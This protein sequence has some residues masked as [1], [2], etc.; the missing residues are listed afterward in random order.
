MHDLRDAGRALRA[1]PLLS[2]AAV[3]SL[4]LGIGASTAIFSIF[5]SLLLKPLPVRTPETLVALA[6]DRAGEDAAL[7]YPIWSAI[8]D[9]GALNDAFVWS[10][11]RLGVANLGEIR[12]LEAVWTSGNFFKVIGLPAIAGRPFGDA[13]DRRGGGPD[14]PVAVLSYRAARRL[15][16]EPSAAIGKT[17]VIERLPFTIVGVTPRGFFGLNIGTDADVVLP[18][19]AEPMLNRVPS[20]LKMWPWLHITGRLTPG[21]TVD[22]ATA[23]VRAVQPHIRELTMPDFSRAEDRNSYLA[24]PWTMRSA[25]NGSSRLRSRYQFVLTSLLAIVA[26]VL[27]IACANI[28]HLQLARTA[29]RR[30][31]YSVRIALG[32]PRLRIV[33]LQAIESLLLAAT[34]AALG[35]TFA[36][37]TGSLIVA[38]LSTWAAT[39]FLDLSPDWRVL[40]V[41]VMT[42]TLTALLF[43]IV[44]AIRA[45]RADPLDALNRSRRNVSGLGRVGDV[46]VIGQIAL[47]MVLVVGAAL[48]GRS[49]AALMTHDLGFDR[50]RV[51]TAVVDVRRSPTPA[52][53]RPELYERIR[54]AVA[55]VAGVESAATSMATPLGSAGVRFTRDVQEAGN[56]TFEG[57]E[58]LVFTT[59][60]SPDWFR[61]FGTRIVAGR[62]IAATDHATTPKVA[63]INDAFARNYFPGV[64]PIGRTIMVGQEPTDRQPMEIV[65][66]VQDA[67]FTS[68][69]DSVEPTLYTSFAQSMEPELI[70]SFPSISVSIRAAGEIPPSRLATSVA[71]AIASVDGAATVSFQT[72]TETLSV[73]YIRERLLAML[74]GYFGAFALLL[75][76]VGVYGVT[77]HAVSR[78]RTEIGVRMAIG[79]STA[80]VVRL[81]LGRLAVLASV[82]IVIGCVLSFWATSLLATLLFQ[83][84]TRDPSSIAA[85][86]VALGAVTLCAGWLP[87]QRASRIDPAEALRE[88]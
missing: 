81:V 80:A 58:V 38:Q 69:R 84:T 52:A 18:L 78:R 82:G 45:G 40:V 42:A 35:L 22:G 21:G 33:R 74:S 64:N 62:D 54:Q 41:T 9:S 24:A 3:L 65:G 48:F 67:A 1:S 49:F 72:L 55:G 5:N 19:E 10:T 70:Q 50:G 77:A 2:V 75:G 86:I 20:R 61:T 39:A 29:S 47:S 43:G 34:G 46:L 30:Y 37:W 60:V 27:L 53:G 4:A 79:A 6:S 13:D 56:P 63:V 57:K 32:A 25:A 23:A 85:A 51:L 66:I 8:R 87:A 17:L 36:G 73:Y 15:F 31:D 12:T 11:D 26:L 71:A 68:V 83:I 59:P 14:G 76:G 16:S 88:S 7:T 28:A 44:P